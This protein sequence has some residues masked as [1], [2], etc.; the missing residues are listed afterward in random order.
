MQAKLV[1]F[2]AF[3]KVKFQD[4]YDN[5]LGKVNEISNEMNEFDIQ[6]NYL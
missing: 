1:N 6:K 2:L 4:K 3:F 5:L